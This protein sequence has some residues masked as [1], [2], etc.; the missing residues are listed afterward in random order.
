[1]GSK[2]GAHIA[3]FTVN[4]IY[5]INYTFAKD[6][7]GGG[8]LRPFGFILTRIIGAVALFWILGAAF[9]QDKI[10][11]KDMFLLA[12]CG[13]FGVAVNQLLFFKGL[14]LTTPINAAIIMTI[15]PV[16]V[17]ILSAILLKEAINIVKIIGVLCGLFGAFLLI[18][19]GDLANISIMDSSTSLGNL[20]VLINATS[21]ALYLIIA[22]PLMNKYNPLT[23]IKWVF[24]FGFIYVIP[25]GW[26]EF[27]SAEWGSFGIDIWWRIAFVV[28][29]TTFLAYL[30]NIFALKELPPSIVSTYIY[31]QPLLAGIFAILLGS[32]RINGLM[33]GS[34]LLIFI[35]VYLV[36]NPFRKA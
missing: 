28:I 16:L 31:L 29:G 19:Q 23:V 18:T 26:P 32:D 8:H 33:I 22:K 7:M 36:S 21:Y 35:G 10:E 4:L 12:L 13:L 20:F 14:D 6:V 5:G 11:R 24:T 27:Q 9:K 34:G 3:L 17:L 15:N 25:F 30:L 2:L 1:M